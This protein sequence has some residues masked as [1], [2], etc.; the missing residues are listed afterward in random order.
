MFFEVAGEGPT[1]LIS[2]NKIRRVLQG[3][4][5]S[6]SVTSTRDNEWSICLLH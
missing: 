4:I 1:I 2:L 6:S 5:Y 3:E